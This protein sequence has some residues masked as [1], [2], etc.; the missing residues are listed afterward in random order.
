M[1]EIEIEVAR[2][3]VAL[4]GLLRQQALNDPA[5][6]AWDVPWQ[7]LGCLA[8]DGCQ[9]LGFGAVLERPFTGGQLVEDYPEGELV[10]TKIDIAVGASLL[11][12]HVSDGSKDSARSCS[13]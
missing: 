8:D 4:P 13:C 6:P 3:C 9:G 7:G 5:E 1:A 11:G 2:V 12:T 10:G